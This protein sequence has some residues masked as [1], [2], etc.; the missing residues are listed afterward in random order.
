MPHQI[1]IQDQKLYSKYRRSGWSSRRPEWPR[2]IKS[3]AR[4]SS[5]PATTPVLLSNASHTNKPK[6][7]V[8]Y[9]VKL[10][11][12]ENELIPV[13]PSKRWRLEILRRR[14]QPVLKYLAS[15][16]ASK[17][18]KHHSRLTQKHPFAHKALGLCITYTYTYTCCRLYTFIAKHFGFGIRILEFYKFLRYLKGKI[19]GY[20]IDKFD[21]ILQVVKTWHFFL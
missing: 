19:N 10:L 15:K 21:W 6:A 18:Q 17:T 13:N 4:S 5:S 20:K 11:Y 9:T 12:S 14:R 7:V 2:Y 8:W 3:R 1:E 16:E